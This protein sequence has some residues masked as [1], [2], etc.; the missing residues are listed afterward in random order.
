MFGV[1]NTEFPSLQVI[2][3]QLTYQ[4][5][6]CSVHILVHLASTFAEGLAVS[7][8]IRSDLRLTPNNECVP[9]GARDRVEHMVN[10]RL[11]LGLNAP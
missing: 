3:F 4:C 2:V 11:R 5:D 6:Q 10:Q 8:E 7:H 9:A 1:V